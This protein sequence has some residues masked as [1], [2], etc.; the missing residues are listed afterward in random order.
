MSWQL[1]LIFLCLGIL[2]LVC[3][4]VAIHDSKPD[5]IKDSELNAHRVTPKFNVGSDAK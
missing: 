5:L 4:V 1:A 2:A 3:L